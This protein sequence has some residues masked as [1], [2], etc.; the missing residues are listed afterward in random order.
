ML[1]L[2]EQKLETVPKAIRSLTHLEQ[3]RLAD[4]WIQIL[5]E[6]IYAERSRS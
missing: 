5:V 1:D 3:I 6:T 4:N 2:R